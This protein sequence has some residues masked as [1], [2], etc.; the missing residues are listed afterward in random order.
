MDQLRAI[1]NRRLAGGPMARLP[2]AL[3]ARVDEA[4]RG[5]LDFEDE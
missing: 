4:L 3:M 5:I 1:D 2:R